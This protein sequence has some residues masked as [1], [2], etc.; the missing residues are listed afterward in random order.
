MSV[1]APNPA[2]N[3]TSFDIELKEKM[4]V[5]VKLL[6]LLGQ[7]VMELPATEYQSGSSKISLEI[8]NLSPGLY[9]LSTQ[10]GQETLSRKLIVE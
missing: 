7:T 8:D 5:S 10:A 6:D 3:N 4:I 9:F 2:S 1:P